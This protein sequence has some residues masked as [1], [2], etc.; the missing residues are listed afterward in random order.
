[1]AVEIVTVEKRYAKYYVEKVDYQYEEDNSVITTTSYFSLTTKND[2]VGL[3]PDFDI[4]K[5]ES[6]ESIPEEVKKLK[7]VIEQD[8]NT[9]KTTSA[10]HY[11]YEWYTEEEPAVKHVKGVCVNCKFHTTENPNLAEYIAKKPFKYICEGQVAISFA[12]EGHYCKAYVK[13][14][15]IEGKD[16]YEYCSAHNSSGECVKYELLEETSDTPVDPK[17]PTETV[18]N[19][20]V[21][22]VENTV[23]ITCNTEGSDIYY[24]TDGSEPT[25]ESTKYT[26]PFEITENVIIKAVAVKDGVTSEVVQQECEFTV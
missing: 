14:D 16:V 3:A 12:S 20:L 26:E 11:F 5:W 24:T 21:D 10:L 6:I 25:T 15:Y 17:E 18:E 7:D 4:E 19:P 8:G 13:A 22:C 9:G 1:M 23:T 2:S